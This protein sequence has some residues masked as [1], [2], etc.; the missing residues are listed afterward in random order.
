MFLDLPAFTLVHVV[1]SVLGIVSGLVVAGG[2]IAN[3][4]LDG[5][6]AFFIAT[7]LL[8]SITGFGFA[9]TK[10]LPPHVFGAV[11]LVL[12]ALCITALYL[13]RLAGRWRGTFVVTAVLA[14][15]LNVLVL[16]VQL[17]L[18]TPPLAALAPTQTEAPFALTQLVVL[19][20]FVYIGWAA[21]HGFRPADATAELRTPGKTFA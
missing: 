4:R 10:V 8:T 5:W 21:W 6:I 19:A 9:F 13:K 2:L 17:F 1:I 18:K 20:L 15:Y 11:S 3:R 16:V 14:L 7:T 12:L